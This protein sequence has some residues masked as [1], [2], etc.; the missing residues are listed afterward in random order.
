M[1]Y[2]KVILQIMILIIP[3]SIYATDDIN[4]QNPL[5]E[6]MRTLDAVFREIVS[7]VAV[8]DGKRVYKSIETLNGLMEKTHQ[9]VESGKVKLPK[10][11][12]RVR[13]F[14]KLDMKFHAELELLSKAARKDKQGKMLVL[15]KKLLEGC[16]N[17]HRVF[18]R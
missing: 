2:F 9:A 8:G 6:E 3:L 17:C 1:T 13:E 5:I 16:L 12:H 10:N 4:F 7:A 14:L 11:Q 18:R 15:T